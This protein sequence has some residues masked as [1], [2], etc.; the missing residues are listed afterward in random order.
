MRMNQH[1]KYRC[2]LVTKE[3]NQVKEIFKEENK[4][5]IIHY[6]CESFYDTD[7]FSLRVTSIAM[8]FFSPQ[9]LLVHSQ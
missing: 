3:W 7:G 1:I 8:R 9:A 5:L 2:E 6:S 4:T